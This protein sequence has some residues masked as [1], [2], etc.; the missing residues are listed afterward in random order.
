[1]FLKND[2]TIIC[3]TTDTLSN[4]VKIGRFHTLCVDAGT[5]TMIMPVSTS[6]TKGSTVMVK[7]YTSDDSDF[8]AFYQKTISAITTNTYQNI[9]TV[10]H[11]LS[12]YIAGDI[13][14]ESVFC[15]SWYPNTL[16]EDAMVYDKTTNRCI[17][18][19]L[20]S[21]NGENTRSKYNATHA[22]SRQPICHQRDMNAVGKK[23][24]TD[25]EFGSC[26]LGSNERTSIAGSSDK[27]TV[28]GHSDT[29]GRRMIS[30]IG[31]EE[32]CGYLW[33]WLDEIGPVGGSEWKSYGEGDY[34]GQSYGMPYMMRAGGHWNN[35][36][37]CGSG[38]RA[39]NETRSGVNSFDGG[40]G[41]SHLIRGTNA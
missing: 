25:N 14:P 17:D 32:C 11:P 38:S 7:P 27:T 34:F 23:L 12:G 19:Y 2:G 18:I 37:D 13:L 26:A 1:M 16:V 10:P 8:K 35:G 41:S 9:A 29:A 30:A 5:M 28:G 6:T 3:Q 21:G 40:R 39:A 20:Q 33:Q 22:V 24:L 4:A 15:L 36:S 31:C